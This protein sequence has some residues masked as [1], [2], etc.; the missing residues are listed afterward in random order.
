MVY[1]DY[2]ANCPVEEEVLNLFYSVT[3]EY[4]ANPNASHKLGL[5][6]KNLIDK[7]TANVANMLKVLKEEIIYTSGASES[8]NL[9]IKGVAGKYHGKHIIS[10]KLEHSSIIAPLMFLQEKG[11]EIDLVDVNENGEVDIDQIIKLIREDTILVS[12]C[13]VDS[14]IGIKQP[15]EKLGKILKSYPNVIFH[16]DASQSIGKVDISFEN[17]DLITVAPHKFYGLNGTGILIKKKNIE[18]NPIIH[19]GR[20]TTIYR[21]GTPSVSNIVCLDKALEIALKNQ[22]IRYKYVLNLK[23]T[24]I[25]ELKK[26]KNIV[27]NSTEKSIPFTLNISV[28]IDS[29]T[30]SK[31]L[32]KHNI[33]LSTKTSCQIDNSPSKSV[34]VLTKNEYLANSSIRISLSHLTTKKDLDLFFKAFKICYEELINGKE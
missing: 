11:Y 14:E 16:T 13:S 4:Y 33:F 24:I 9:A 25:N 7:S 26:Y 6:V 21:S 20:S 10:T 1:L 28:G 29:N 34:Y 19:G 17:V 12:V 27:I 8:N 5:E 18:L 31:E 23:N 2:A 3:K 15:I 22:E 30:F 32:E